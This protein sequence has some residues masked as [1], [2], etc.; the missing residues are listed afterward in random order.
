MKPAISMVGETIIRLGEIAETFYFI[1]KGKVEIIATD[2]S[3]RIAILE[4]GAYFGEIGLL[5]TKN[6]TTTV[7]ALT[8]CILATLDKNIFDNLM[9]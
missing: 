4:E 5:L 6:C 7:K 1:K 3:T 9:E 8:N 2:N